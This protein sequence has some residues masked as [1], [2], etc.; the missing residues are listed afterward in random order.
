ML[1][2]CNHRCFAR[3]GR[4][5][6]KVKMQ[7]HFVTIFCGIWL[8][9]SGYHRQDLRKTSYVIHWMSSPFSAWNTNE[10]SSLCYWPLELTPCVFVWLLERRKLQTFL[11]TFSNRLKKW[12]NFHG[13]KLLRFRDFWSIPRNFTS[14]KFFK[15]GLTR[16]LMS[17]NFFNIG[18]MR[19]FMSRKFKFWPPTNFLSLNH[20]FR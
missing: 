3:E 14:T 12:R 17:I 8:A 11:S 16:N 7:N 10:Y 6:S 20:I 15:I 18:Y 5:I 9:L 13:P 19:K 2:F 1:I 4:L